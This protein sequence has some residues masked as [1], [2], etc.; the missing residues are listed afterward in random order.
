MLSSSIG[1]VVLTATTDGLSRRGSGASAD[2]PVFVLTIGPFKWPPGGPVK[3]AGDT[4]F[5]DPVALR[6]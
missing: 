2:L 4:G 6:F 1:L 3:L 5:T